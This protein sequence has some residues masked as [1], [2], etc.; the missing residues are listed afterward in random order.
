MIIE[1][2]VAFA[3]IEFSTSSLTTEAG[4]ST[5]SPAAILLIVFL[6]N[7]IIVGLLFGIYY[8]P[9]LTSLFFYNSTKILLL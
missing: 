7:C 6:S 4:R 2:D 3:S 9:Y 8:L 5:T 1:I